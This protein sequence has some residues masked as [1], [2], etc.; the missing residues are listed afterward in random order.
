LIYSN[1]KKSIENNYQ[2]IKDMCAPDQSDHFICPSTE[3]FGTASVIWGLIGPGRIFSPGHIYSVLVFFFLI[4]AVSPIIPW[5]ITRRYPNS[6]FK[7]VNFPVIY[8]GT[9]LIPPATAVNYVPWGIVGFIFQYYI[10]RKSFSWW[11]KYNYVL[12]AALDSGVAI[13]AVIIFFTLQYPKNGE[14][15]ANNVLV[16]WGNAQAFNN[17]DGNSEPLQTVASGSTFGPTSW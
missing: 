14:I 7:Y 4:G 12:S 15:G 5:V 16:W 1:S 8:S 6:F 13:G 2:N 11:S 17:S 3:V 9:G 10:R